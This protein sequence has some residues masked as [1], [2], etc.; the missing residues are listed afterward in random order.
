ML[1]ARRLLL[2]D[3][4]RE[5]L[6]GFDRIAS[7]LGEA[8]SLR[9]WRTAPAM[10]SDLEAELPGARLISLDHDLYRDA[11]SD[12]D[13]G[14]G[15]MIADFLAQ[16]SPV[17]P[18]IVHSTNT[19]AAWGMFNALAGAGWKVELVHHTNQPAWIEELWLPVAVKLFSDPP[20]APSPPPQTPPPRVKA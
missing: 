3:D 18:V 11:E 13:P 20:T 1:I 16:R 7:R 5:R 12:P 8:W 9:T 4:D 6:R 14:S 17:C 15:R 19:D 2:L 10:L